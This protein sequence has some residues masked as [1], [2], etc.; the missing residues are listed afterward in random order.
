MKATDAVKI[1]KDM[2]AAMNSWDLEKAASFFADDLIYEDVGSGLVFHGVKEYID[3]A[4]K[5]RVEFPDRKWEMKSVFSDGHNIATEAVWSGTFTQSV[6]NPEK[7][8]T[9]KHVSVRCVSI[10]E[11]RDGKICR[12][13]DYAD[14]LTFQKQ[15]G[16]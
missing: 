7:L 4:K 5:V 9:G 16:L 1:M 14:Y 3:F 12:N 8:A 10:T 13:R 15:L 2:M 11:L 6:I